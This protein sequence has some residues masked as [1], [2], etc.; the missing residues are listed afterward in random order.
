[1][2]YN[3]TQIIISVCTFPTKIERPFQDTTSVQECF[4][5]QPFTEDCAKNKPQAIR[6]GFRLHVVTT[7]HIQKVCTLVVVGS[8][9]PSLRYELYDL[10]ATVIDL[11]TT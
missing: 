11:V 7:P 3:V 4:T 2:N 6:M 5:M 9:I 8:K 10:N 1:M